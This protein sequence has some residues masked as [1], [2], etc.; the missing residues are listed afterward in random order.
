MGGPDRLSLKSILI[1]SQFRLI[2]SHN[3]CHICLTTIITS[4][5]CGLK[6]P[7]LIGGPIER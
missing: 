3:I 7:G 5:S 6:Y 1:V 2:S 4:I